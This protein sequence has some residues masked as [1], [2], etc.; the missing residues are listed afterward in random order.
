MY[1]SWTD[2]ASCSIT[3]TA[4]HKVLIVGQF[5]VSGITNEGDAFARVLADGSLVDGEYWTNVSAKTPG[6]ASGRA[7]LPVSRVVTLGSST[8][9]ITL[10]GSYYNRGVGTTVYAYAS[11]I[12]AID[13]G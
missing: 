12:S 3:L 1:S 13:L 6:T 4:S 2:I 5:T 9:T 7:T 11:S 8:H 10:Q